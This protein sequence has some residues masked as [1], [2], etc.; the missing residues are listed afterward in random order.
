VNM[1]EQVG[2]CACFFIVKMKKSF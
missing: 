2:V 1:S